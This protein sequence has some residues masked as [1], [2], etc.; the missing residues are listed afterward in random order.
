MKK[1]FIVVFALVLCLNLPELAFGQPEVGRKGLGVKIGVVDPQNLGATVGFGALVDLGRI[2]SKLNLTLDLDYWAKSQKSEVN[3]DFIGLPSTNAFE[4]SFSDLAIGGTLKYIF[5]TKTSKISPFAGGG[6]GLHILRTKT[7]T[8]GFD[9]PGF[10]EPDFEFPASEQT[11]SN[12][13]IG[14]RFA[15]GVSFKLGSRADGFGE[16]RYWLV[17]DFNTAAV[18]AGI[19]FKLK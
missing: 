15:G 16:V 4:A 6:F 10:E 13:K 14:L 12:T 1:N 3:L 9:I 8:S 18:L 17:D 2:S 11:H 19:V 5:P 7:K